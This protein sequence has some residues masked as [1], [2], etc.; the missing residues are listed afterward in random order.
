M[1]YFIE[2]LIIH[3][4]ELLNCILA[5]GSLFILWS[6]E[7][8]IKILLMELTSTNKDLNKLTYSLMNSLNEVRKLIHK[9]R[10]LQQNQNREK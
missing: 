6:M 5:G 4:V 1:D 2:W 9:H 8:D 7:H 10:P 3:G